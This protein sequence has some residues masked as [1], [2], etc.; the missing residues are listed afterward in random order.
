MAIA[1]SGEIT[2]ISPAYGGR[3]TDGQ[4]TAN[5]GFLELL[6]PGALVLADKGFPKINDDLNSKGALLVMP[7][8]G[9]KI[10]IFT[11]NENDLGYRCSCVRIQCG[12]GNCKNEIF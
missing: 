12:K 4:L 6:W 3:T 2:F 9:S 7:P 11:Q 1:P 10:R 8:M 5:C